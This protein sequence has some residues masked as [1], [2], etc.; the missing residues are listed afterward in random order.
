MAVGFTGT[1]R[2]LTPQQLRTLRKFKTRQHVFHHGACIG[3]DTQAALWFHSQGWQ[4][5]A[6]PGRDPDPAAMAVSHEVHWPDPTHPG[7]GWPHIQ[8]NH[9]IVDVSDVLI[10]TPAG[11]KDIKRGSGT[12]ATIRYATTVRKGI[13]I[14]WPNGTHT[15]A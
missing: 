14:I 12:W 13:H 8:R 2:G 9:L 1:R 5:H 7:E 10:A 4:I 15:L 6:W 3:A 11:Y